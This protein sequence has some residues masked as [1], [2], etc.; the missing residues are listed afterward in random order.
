LTK[1]IPP[2]GGFRD[3]PIYSTVKDPA[4]RQCDFWGPGGG[5]ASVQHTLNILV[6]SDFSVAFQ[7]TSDMM[8]VFYQHTLILFFCRYKP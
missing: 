6:F 2:L 3:F 1:K 7:L 5:L 4:Q 8:Y